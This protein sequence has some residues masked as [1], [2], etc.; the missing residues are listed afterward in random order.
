MSNYIQREELSEIAILDVTR[1]RRR[2]CRR[3][4][5]AR[6]ARTQ[7]ALVYITMLAG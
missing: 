1:E 2:R 3:R 6:I 4:R 5:R 7:I